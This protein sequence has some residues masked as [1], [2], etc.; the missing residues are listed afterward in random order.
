MQTR[1]LS[2]RGSRRP[3]AAHARWRSNL[4]PR[5]RRVG[6]ARRIPQPGAGEVAGL[7]PTLQRVPWPPAWL[8]TAHAS[9]AA[10]P[11]CCSWDGFP[12]CSANSVRW[13]VP[14]PSARGR[15]CR[16]FTGPGHGGKWKGRGRGLS[17]RGGVR[18]WPHTGRTP[19]RAA[20][21]TDASLGFRLPHPEI[22][23]PR[24]LVTAAHGSWLH[25]HLSWLGRAGQ[26]RAGRVQWLGY[27]IGHRPAWVAPS[28][29]CHTAG[30]WGPSWAV[31]GAWA[32]TAWQL[33][34]KSKFSERQGV[35]AAGRS[36]A[37]DW[38]GDP[39][40]TLP[41]SKRCHRP[42]RPQAR[43]QE[44]TDK[45]GARHVPL[46][47]ATELILKKCPPPPPRVPAT[48][49]QIAF[50]LYIKQFGGSPLCLR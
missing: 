13:L 44:E 23:P 14:E 45:G 29:H 41:S 15:A 42:A 32:L 46:G 25:D 8:V 18:R 12:S 47:G 50:P 28:P 24:L 49:R 43:R 36:S 48:Y 26:G 1:D 10:G 9:G 34:S 38:R 2:G 27:V 22:R 35:R 40:S 6:G 11:G 5:V 7:G 21:G 16:P 31:S 33:S 20:E 39:P 4:R 30:G 37:H 17:P 19:L 3:A